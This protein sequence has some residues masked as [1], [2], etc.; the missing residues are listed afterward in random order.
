MNFVVAGI[1]FSRSLQPS[2]TADKQICRSNTRS[3]T[4]ISKLATHGLSRSIVFST[5]PGPVPGPALHSSSLSQSVSRRRS[6]V[7]KHD[8]REAAATYLQQ[9]LTTTSGVCIS[10]DYSQCYDRMRI[11]ITTQFL[12]RIGWPPSVVAILQQVWPTHR[13]I[14]DDR[15]VHPQT[16]TGSGV[17]QGCPFAPMAFACFMACGHKSVNEILQRDY[18]FFQRHNRQTPRST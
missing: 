10:L 12:L 5:D 8:G 7:C 14:E 9:Q 2:S 13:H 15:H 1:K 11:P 6:R 4:D 18:V 16:L 17:P 3:R